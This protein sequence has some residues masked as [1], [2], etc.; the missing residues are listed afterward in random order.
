MAV[1]EA[2][3]QEVIAGLTRTVAGLLNLRDEASVVV[4]TYADAGGLTAQAAGMLGADGLPLAGASGEGPAGIS[5][6]VTD[7]GR[8][9]AV[10]ALA[11]VALFLV[12]SAVKK[13]VPAAGASSVPATPSAAELAAWGAGDGVRLV[14]GEDMLAGEAG[15]ADSLLVGHEVAEEHLQ[16]GQMV[17]QVQSLVKEN[18]D[19]AAALVRRWINAA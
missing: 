5:R 17:E 14:G 18:P 8:P 12:S 7:Y 19:A 1:L 4:N 16:A 3:E 9:T 15:G 6:L 11:A 10:L 13:S 2:Y